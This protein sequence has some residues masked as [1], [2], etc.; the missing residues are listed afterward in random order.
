MTN[1]E[2]ISSDTHVCVSVLVHCLVVP[3]RNDPQ[4]HSAKHM[5]V[6]LRLF[7][8]P[9]GS[10]RVANCECTV[11]APGCCLEEEYAQQI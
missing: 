3:G 7:V 6:V 9:P 4:I 10:T 5:R 1:K 2:S 8:V 11:W